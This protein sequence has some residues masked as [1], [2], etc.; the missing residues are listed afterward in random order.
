M[1]SSTCLGEETLAL[2]MEGGLDDKGLFEVDAH[3]DGCGACKHLVAT[4]CRGL[5]STSRVRLDDETWRAQTLTLSDDVGAA[6][7]AEGRLVVPERYRLLG[8]IGRGG[9]GE[10]HSAF[11][12]V[13]ERVVALKCIRT[14]RRGIEHVRRFIDEAVRTAQLE[15]PNIIP[16]YDAGVL[17][18]GSP[19][20]TMK[21]VEGT[22]LREVLQRRRAGD[23]AAAAEYGEHRLLSAFSH[24]CLAVDFAHSRGVLHRDIKPSNV[25]L[26]DFGEVYVLDWGLAKALHEADESSPPSPSPSPRD[27]FETIDGAVLGTPGYMAPEQRDRALGPVDARAD[28]YALG[29]LLLEILT[30]RPPPVEDGEAGPSARDEMAP[31]LEAVIRAATAP[32]PSERYARA[33]E[34]SAAVERYLE[35]DRDLERR[36]GLS[37]AHAEAARDALATR[38]ISDEERRTRAMRELSRALALDPEN[39]TAT[40]ALMRLLTEPP[41]DLPRD[42]KERMKQQ[43]EETVRMGARINAPFALLLLAAIPGLLWMGVRDLGAAI[44]IILP[45]FGMAAGSWLVGYVR[46]GTSLWIQGAVFALTALAYVAM[47]RLFGPLLL[48]P[49]LASTYAACIQVHPSA[50]ARRMGFATGAVVLVAPLLLE[51]WGALPKSYLFSAEGITVRPQALFL[52]ETPTLVVLVCANLG[53]ALATTWF[54]GRI[55]DALSDAQRALLLHAWQLERLLPEEPREE[56]ATP[57]A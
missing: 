31:E 3:V 16:I 11:D 25:M 42:V 40:T 23:P 55:R 47:S 9:M 36:R 44:A 32:R 15:H 48:I 5:S 1:S 10:V 33:R 54:V 18:D 49:T 20:F 2:L 7:P 27:R 6:C 50:L 21:R 17:P 24:V 57:P 53:I 34:L 30:G 13:L 39:R 43:D 37:V 38:G 28:V 29:V 12:T 45:I 14:D 22:S 35:G 4:L 51:L 41:A 19:Y 46:W 56:A 52:P 8:S 26:G